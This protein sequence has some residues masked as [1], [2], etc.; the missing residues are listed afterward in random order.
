MELTLREREVLYLI[1]YEYSNKVI[2]NIL[3]ITENTVS[4]YRRRLFLKFATK[5]SAGLVRRAFEEGVLP[6]T[7]D[8]KIIGKPLSTILNKY[9]LG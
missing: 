8:T 9:I 6:I 7:Y 5:N 1:A 3:D 4:S 2:S